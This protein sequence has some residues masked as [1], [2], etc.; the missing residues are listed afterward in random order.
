MSK[1]TEKA[2]KPPKLEKAEKLDTAE[3]PEKAEKTEKASKNEKPAKAD[4]ASKA[5]QSQ[6]TAK[7]TANVKEESSIEEKGLPKYEEEFNEWFQEI[8]SRA[9]IIDYRYPLKGCGVWL[10]YGF[11]LRRKALNIMRE[12]LESTPIPHQEYLFPM[13]I[14]DFL[15]LKEKEHVKGFEDEV[16]WVT[17]GGLTPLDVKLA[18]R[19]TSETIIYPMMKLWVRSHTDLPLK[20]YQIVNTFRWEGKNTRPLIRVREITTFKEAHTAH[21]T[22]EDAESQIREAVGIYKNFFN[23]LGISY[24]ITQRPKWDTFPGANYTIAFDAIFPGMHRTLQIGTVHNLGTVFAQTYEIKYENE[25]G[26]NVFVHQTCYGIS[27]RVI[28][29]VISEHGDDK[30]LKIPPNIAPIQVII[31]PVLYKNKEEIVIEESKKVHEMLKQANIASELDLRDMKSGRKYYEW[32]EKGVPIR[33]EVGPKDVEKQA[34]MMV[35]R[36]TG[37]KQ[38]IPKSELIQTLHRTFNDM[39]ST[40]KQNTEKYIQEKV[41]QT[42]D[43]D[44]AYELIEKNKGVVE[45]PFCGS[46]DCAKVLETTVA[47]LK[48]L[49]IPDRYLKVLNPEKS[50]ETLSENKQIFC[51]NCSN[52]V[53]H[54]WR[55]ARTF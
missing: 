22:A 38:S 52:P 51:V 31:I 33:L 25:K 27:E 7:H 17:H 8:I 48:F 43:L 16:Y 19:P 15:F 6:N 46:E 29:A 10:P 39:I 5:D 53:K 36:D 20:T 54:Y 21:A 32:E 41:I 12:L 14:P 13:L 30:G 28:A 40:M 50:E 23:S 4:K 37:T 47:G 55:I 35:R 2:E 9:E 44:T 34:V 42:E 24:I 3:K 49:G 26:E 11:K 45:I 1:K 18:L